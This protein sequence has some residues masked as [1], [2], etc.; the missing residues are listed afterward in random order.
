VPP[1]RKTELVPQG[2]GNEIEQQPARQMKSKSSALRR[3]EVRNDRE[4]DLLSSVPRCKNPCRKPAGS[5]PNRFKSRS[6]RK[7]LGE[8]IC[9]GY[10]YSRLTLFLADIPVTSRLIQMAMNYDIIKLIY[11]PIDYVPQCHVEFLF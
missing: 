8:H 4:K 11:A 5:I 2:A 9:C 3:S 10:E 1:T 6:P 7:S